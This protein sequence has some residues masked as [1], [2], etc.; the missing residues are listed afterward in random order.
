MGRQVNL[1][2]DLLRRK[3]SAKVTGQAAIA[4]FVVAERRYGC[5]R[6]VPLRDNHTIFKATANTSKLSSP[7]FK[8]RVVAKIHLVQNSR[9]HTTVSRN[10]R[11]KLF[12][13][14]GVLQLRGITVNHVQKARD[15]TFK[16]TKEFRLVNRDVTRLKGAFPSNAVVYID[17]VDRVNR[18]MCPLEVSA[19]EVSIANDLTAFTASHCEPLVVSLRGIGLCVVQTLPQEDR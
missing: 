9:C 12:N 14:I 7:T 8:V 10:A 11:T 15:A 2:K 19:Q 5:K 13:E 18:S 17:F 16:L 6:F 4:I 3:G 1:D